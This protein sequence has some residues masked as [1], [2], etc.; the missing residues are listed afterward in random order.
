MDKYKFTSVVA[1][2]LLDS[3]LTFFPELKE[4]SVDC[5]A[6]E[7]RPWPVREQ[8]WNC[9]PGGS[10][11]PAATFTCWYRTQAGPHGRNREESA[12]P[13]PEGPQGASWRRW[14]LG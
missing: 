3:F 12:I 5:R 13:S 4:Q 6:G 7:A 9:G 11:R 8:G 2:D 14:Q 1:Q 10:G